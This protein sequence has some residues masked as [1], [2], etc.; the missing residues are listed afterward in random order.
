VQLQP[1]EPAGNITDD[2]R[3]AFV[4]YLASHDR[5]I[6]EVIDPPRKDC[7]ALFENEFAGMT[8]VPVTLA[9]LEAARETCI[10]TINAALTD[11]ERRFSFRS[12]RARRSGICS[13]CRASKSYRPFIGRS[14]TSREWTGPSMRPCSRN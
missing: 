10:K 8:T 6:H 2:I 7:R 4:V 9:E 14:P 13:A 11:A 3:K 12:R 1:L 5:S